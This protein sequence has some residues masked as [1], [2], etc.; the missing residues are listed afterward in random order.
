MTH[1]APQPFSGR[2]IGILTVVGIAAFLGSLYFMI[3]GDD[4]GSL[5]SSGPDAFSRSAVGDR[6]FIE[7]LN[8]RGITTMVSR[9]DSAKRAGHNGLLVLA[10]PAG[11]NVSIPVLAQTM[12]GP[13]ELIVLPK[14]AG[15]PATLNEAWLA[16]MA[17]LPESTV[18]KVLHQILP[19]ASIRRGA[20]AVTIEAARFGGDV[21]LTS[22]QYIGGNGVSAVLATADGVLIAEL[23]QADRRVWVLADPDL[24][25]N[26]GLDDGDNA[27]VALNIIE[28][29]RPQD[30]VVVF[31]EVIH[32]HE[33]RP[34]LLREAFR[35]PF[36]GVM[37]TG[38]ATL[39]LT[40][41]A[42]ALRFGSPAPSQPAIAAGKTTLLGNA[43][44]LLNRA[45]SSSFLLQRYARMI[46]AQTVA[47]LHGP[48]GVA[49]REQVVWL[50]RLATSRG[51]TQPLH[52]IIEEVDR[53]TEAASTQPHA[54]IATALRLYRWK[55]EVL[56]GNISD[57]RR[58]R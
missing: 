6:A 47:A 19:S 33:Q 1:A 39:A 54:A 34:N 46:L 20:E 29:L 44:D 3:F 48:R 21:R 40:I 26:H 42:G 30:A 4:T 22:P 11:D 32:G 14:W 24:I 53:L 17:L 55:Q 8:R 12:H 28:Q 16:S 58:R 9:F 2:T 57:S 23:P 43:A 41:W 13:Q 18:N 52:S 10:Q 56:D 50:D 27:T 38:I 31:D 35:P 5:K 45:G 37:I 49:A 51:A 15:E 25:S 36:L 7:L